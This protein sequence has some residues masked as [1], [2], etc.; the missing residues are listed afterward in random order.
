MTD[1]QMNR[2]QKIL[3]VD[4]EPQN[5]AVLKQIL[6][7]DYQL[8]FGRSGAE[9]LAAAF[10]HG[11]SLIMLDIQMPDMNGYE[12]C[13]RLK[14][15]QRTEAIPVIFV[16]T[17]ADCGNEAA[18]FAVGAVDYII[19]PISPPI[20]QAR[21]RTH[22]SLVRATLLEQSHRDAIY[23]LG[24][25]GHYNDNNTGVHIWRMASY[26]AKLASRSGWSMESCLQFEQSA[27]MH[28]TGKIGIPNAI[29][30]KPTKLDSAEWEV[31]KTHSRIGH[32]ILSKSKAPTFRL[33]AEIALYHH[34]RYDGSGYPCGLAGDEIP[35]SARIIALCDVFDA[36]SMKRPNKD[37]WPLERV[38]ETIREDSG[39]HFDP[40][41]VDQFK[42]IL[43]QILNIK[44]RWD[45]QE[46]AL[47]AV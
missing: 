35:E 26:S 36:L 4:D 7:D 16:T 45:A 21:V 1:D 22:L 28:D 6:G 29:M 2:S 46:V 37:A 39:S 20:V 3:I 38:L 12:V 34:E 15:D 5:L 18:G 14:A 23:M 41:L 42:S 24:E 40:R 47:A 33:A 9:A 30:R 44:T 8:L 11:P 19:K 32:E 17:L 31:M 27:A 25:A 10:K 13:K 43:P